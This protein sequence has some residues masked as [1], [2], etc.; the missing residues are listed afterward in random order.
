MLS[1]VRFGDSGSQKRPHLAWA[2]VGILAASSPAQLPDGALAK[3][4]TLGPLLPTLE[5]HDF[6]DFW[7]LARG[8]ISPG[9]LSRKPGDGKLLS[10][11]LLLFVTL[12]FK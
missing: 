10:L 5:T 6:S 11:S 12:S 7:L 3:Q 2:A 8:W 9:H 1:C 4:Q